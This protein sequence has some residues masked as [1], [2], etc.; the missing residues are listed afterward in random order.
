MIRI[1]EGGPLIIG[2]IPKVWKG[3]LMV[4]DKD[5]LR[6]I[7]N[8][9]CPLI[10]V[11]IV[12]ALGVSWITVHVSWTE[13]AYIIQVSVHGDGTMPTDIAL[14]DVRLV[15]DVTLTSMELLDLI[16]M[17]GCIGMMYRVNPSDSMVIPI[18]V[19]AI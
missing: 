1:V 16:I 11:V 10:G 3:L 18:T 9:L 8:G 5:I 13:T 14:V 7:G 19:D 2:L 4:S 17:L 15:I 6:G 12:D